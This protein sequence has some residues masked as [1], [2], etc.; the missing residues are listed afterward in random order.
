VIG[1]A[2][3]AAGFFVLLASDV[4][5]HGQ[6]G[7]AAGAGIVGALLFAL[8]PGPL[9][10][11]M[12]RRDGPAAKDDPPNA[13]DRC[14]AAMF[15]CI[16]RRPGTAF[17]LGAALVGL[18]AAS[19]P[20]L[21]FESDI[22][23]FE[24]RDAAV[25][26]AQAAIARTWG[27][28][29]SQQLIAVP[30]PDVQT[31]LAR[32]DA[33]VDALRPLKGVEFEGVASTSA[34][35]PAVATQRRRSDAWR[36]YWTSERRARVRADLV[37]AASQYRIKPSTFDPYFASL[38]TPPAPLTPERLAGTPLD[39]VIARQLSVRPGDVLGLVVVTGAAKAGVASWKDLVRRAVPEARILSGRGLAD[40]V[41][42]AT[43]REFASLALPA[44]LLVGLLLV[45][46]YRSFALACVGVF[47]LIGGLAVTAGLLVVCGERLNMLNA[48]VALPV[49]GL[50]VDYAIFLMDAMRDAAREHP[51]DAPGRIAVIG[52]RMGTMIGDVLTTL[53]GA[54]AML[55]A[56]T[57]P[58]F[59]I[60]L[61]LTAGIGGAMVVAWLMVPQ[62]MIWTGNSPR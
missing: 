15:G 22:R 50:G 37:S 12:G 35:M 40:A 49:F 55:F 41:V 61:A 14:A 46:Y 58:I 57:P 59:S 21:R 7:V 27:D 5:A 52:M 3:S 10:A 19:A 38:D 36:A 39:A 31:V 34:V 56:S 33:L 30:G 17:A 45:A 28:V 44:L 20:F 11:A 9:L 23:R 62:A 6:L 54:V 29:F 48:A 42:G 25:D 51:G 13:L 43:R 4:P 24:V 53:A 1:A 26:G 18:G 16:L 32:T 8:L 47:P 2:T 60:G